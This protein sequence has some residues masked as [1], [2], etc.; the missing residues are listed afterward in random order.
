MIAEVTNLAFYRAAHHQ[1]QD[2]APT[3]KEKSHAL[4][5][6]ARLMQS[7]KWRKGMQEMVG[8]CLTFSISH[9]ALCSL[10]NKACKREKPAQQ[11]L[12]SPDIGIPFS[13]CS[14]SP[15]SEIFSFPSLNVLALFMPFSLF[16][17]MT[18]PSLIHA[19]Q[20]KKKNQALKNSKE[21]LQ[22]VTL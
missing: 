16:P 15:S 8:S 1:N 2:S 11:F 6:E 14:R 20:K 3:S 19:P 9:R 21:P 10:T 4:S 5:F 7:S 22:S 12:T 13:S 18:L 17:Y